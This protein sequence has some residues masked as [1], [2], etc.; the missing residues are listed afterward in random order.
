MNTQMLPYLV[1]Q[2][3]SETYAVP[4]HRVEEVLRMVALTPVP[5]MPAW[6]KGMLNLRGEALPV[7]DLARWLDQGDTTIHL[8]TPIVVIRKEEQPL[9]ILVEA[10]HGVE[11]LPAP[12]VGARVTQM[13]RRLVVVLDL[14]KL[15]EATYS[16]LGVSRL[17]SDPAKRAATRSWP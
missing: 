6:F 9:G 16:A 5:G 13:G 15:V 11:T 7:A 8:N 14:D 12:Q 3:N 10:V 4:V 1:F 17:S 2:V